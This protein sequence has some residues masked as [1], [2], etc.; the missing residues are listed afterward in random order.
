[1]RR[2]FDMPFVMLNIKDGGFHIMVRATVNNMSANFLIDTGASQTVFNKL[3]VA[4]FQDGVSFVK[5]E[6]VTSG[7]DKTEM[8]A[9]EFT[10]EA[11]RIGELD[12]SPYKG[13][14]LDM[15][16]INELYSSLGLPRIDAILGGDF[17]KKH[18]ASINYKRKTLRLYKPMSAKDSKQR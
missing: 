11:L 1:M 13:I 16:H 14:A 15:S 18:K 5:K 3:S 17:L 2:Y 7:I 8:Q 12:F 6:G 4:E 9:E 10:V